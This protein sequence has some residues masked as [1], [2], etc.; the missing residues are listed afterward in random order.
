[1]SDVRVR[2]APS[3]TGAPHVGTA[4][5]ALFNLAFARRHGGRFLLRIEDTDQTR[6]RP[7][8]EAQL[9]ASLAWT[10]LQWDEGPDV[11]GPVGPY[12]QSERLPI[13]REHARQLV[14]A[15]HAYPCF[16]TPE[17]L[18]AL[19]QEQLASKGRLG[20]DGH[21]RGLDV[22]EARARLTAGEPHVIRLQ[23]PPEGTCVF[24][25]LLRGQI[26][27]E[28]A[29]LDDQVLLK[30]DGF[31]TYHLA[32]VVDDHL[33]GISH[34]IRGEEWI[35]SMPKHLRLYECFGWPCPVH[36][37]LPLLLNPDKSKMSKRRNPTSIDY[38]RRAGYLPQALVNYLALMAYPPAEGGEEK[39]AFAAL[40]ERFDLERINL[41][42]S[43]F[44][45][46]KLS[47]LNG[48]YLREDLSGADILRALKGW[49]VNDAYLEQI[50]PLMQPR[51]ETL[52]DF[53]PTCNFFF[54]RQVSPKLEDLLPAKREA[55][56]AVD[57]LQTAVWALEAA[58]PWSRDAVEAAVK[59]VG[60][61]WDW[62]VR[63]VTRPLFAAV[64]GQPVGP[65][66]YESA[67]L[68]GS[69]VTRA[70]LLAA[71][72]VLGG[73][74]KKKAAALEKRWRG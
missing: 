38:Y 46:E 35:S 74:S 33:M 44:D 55:A 67:A 73:L 34:V 25:D 43:V 1:M 17:R 22:A 32:V 20:Y 60:A 10:G 3:P 53:L 39:F 16:C 58:V 9:L 19:R 45:L 72:E 47:W 28:Y 40:V 59:R 15:G 52:G 7:E 54:A 29:R 36:A 37:H 14:E 69:D 8:Y 23:M 71:I 65:P 63:D 24:T 64:M 30:T 5:Q 42:G 61:F 2:V 13:Y 62:P 50:I 6:S 26:A 51:M 31:P 27:F 18:A 4:Y 21:C 41:G 48:R 12:R 57:V 70:R 56:D 68:L 66:L 11:G 49:L